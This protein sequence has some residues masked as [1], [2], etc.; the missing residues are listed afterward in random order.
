MRDVQLAVYT[1]TQAHLKQG[2]SG[3]GLQEVR[4]VLRSRRSRRPAVTR[5]G[6][7]PASRT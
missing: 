5:D 7:G 2:V 1:V 6:T 4:P 3:T